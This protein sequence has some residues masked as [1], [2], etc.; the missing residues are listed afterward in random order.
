[1]YLLYVFSNTAKLFNII[2]ESFIPLCTLHMNN[3]NFGSAYL[4]HTLFKKWQVSVLCKSS[5]RYVANE[6]DN[7]Q[8]V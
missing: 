5:S 7:I 1:M 2:F 4:T 6:R 8:H 3:N